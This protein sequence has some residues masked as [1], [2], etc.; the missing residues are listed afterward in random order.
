MPIERPARALRV[1]YYNLE[2]WLMPSFDGIPT[3]L[4]DGG[5]KVKVDVKKETKLGHL[6]FLDDDETIRKMKE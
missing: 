5:G 4:Y 2:G 1:R 3:I 6:K